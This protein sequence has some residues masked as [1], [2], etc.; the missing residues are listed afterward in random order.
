[1]K[2]MDGFLVK[3]ARGF[4]KKLL[5]YGVATAYMRRKYGMEERCDNLR[6]PGV[7]RRIGRFFV[8]MLP[9]GA[10]EW[11]QSRDNKRKSS[12][13]RNKAEFLGL[14]DR[15]WYV[16]HNPDVDFSAIDPL[17][18][19]FE[20]G[21]KEGRDP[22]ACFSVG[23]YLAK[24]DDVLKSGMNPLA[25]F[26]SRGRWEGR[27]AIAPGSPTGSGSSPV[28]R[29][30]ACHRTPAPLFSVVVASYNYEQLVLETLESLVAQTFRNFEVVVVDDG[31][32]DA[33]RENIRRFIDSHQECDIEITLLTH[34]GN[35]NRGLAETVRLGVEKSRG[36][37][38]AFCESDDLWK[39]NHLAVVAKAVKK[40]RGQIA[41]IVND[42][43][44][45]GDAERVA[46]FVGVRDSRRARLMSGFNSFSPADFRRMNYVLT[47]SAACARR[48]VLASCDFH[49]KGRQAALDWWLWRQVLFS[50]PLFY[51]DRRLTKWRMHKSL[52]T[53]AGAVDGM[54]E[55]MARKQKEFISAGDAVLR[56]QH[57]FSAW[58]KLLFTP[59]PDKPK[60]G[61]WLR[62]R[63]KRLI[64]YCIQRAYAYKKYFI[65]Y[66]ALGPIWAI[67]PFGLVCAVKGMNPDVG[68]GKGVV[69]SFLGRMFRSRYRMSRDR[70]AR[71]FAERK[72]GLSDCR[73]MIERNSGT[74]ILVVLHLFYQES[75]PLI[76]MYLEN[77]SRYKVDLV[78]TAVEGGCSKGTIA[79]IK[80]FSPSAR[81]MF[82]KNRGFDIGPFVLALNG[83]DLDSYDIV[84][85][86]HSKGI[87]RPS[88]FIYGQVFKYSDW[89]FN[90][91]DGVL[92][93]LVVHELIDSLKGG[94]CKLAAASNLIVA[95]PPHKQRFVKAF[96]AERGIEYVEDYVF[97]AGTC[98]AAS[99]D[100]FKPLKAM[101]LT[102]DDFA[103]AERGVFSAAH[104][105]ERTMCFPAKGACKGFFVNRNMYPRI[106]ESCRGKSALRLLDD[107][108]FVLD[109]DFFYRVLETRRVRSYEVVRMR[110]GDIQR[111]RNDGTICAL[112]ECEPF[113]YLKGDTDSY[114]AYCSD[115]LNATGFRMS[116]DRFEKLR[117]D[118]ET[119]DP[120][121]M[122]VVRGA[123]N[124][125]IDGQHRSCILL[126]RFGPDHEID[127]LRIW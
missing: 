44:I 40:A 101:G 54:T 20:T 96:C 116:T 16:S 110:L 91:F 77:L 74:R 71:F 62:G 38:V 81:I 37:Y 121:H 1:M 86:L 117:N 106:T 15:E 70:R 28:D 72:K 120:R 27:D 35:E 127:V 24:Y 61:K 126:D 21:W 118:M 26:I 89:F 124:I 39:P 94:R 115:N 107:P 9:Y 32:T 85:K 88:I 47:F 92:G 57:P 67:L 98:F 78:V 22:S 17:A 3:K 90:L 66:P 23:G 58:W 60:F 97:V 25:H 65:Y 12:R 5:P 99:A 19:F 83:I 56:R 18:H 7:F 93:G 31:S 95:D 123:E 105:L 36:E 113:R 55:E 104:A 84:F 43:E 112:S 63:V 34:P 13:L 69:E 111:R 114:E 4:V 79:A 64:P 100:V 73:D 122:P 33:S 50:R 125:I 82:C 2:Y 80:K 14:F 102:E 48:D 108:R 51:I 49:P 119:F 103:P 59:S 52:M 11:Y 10:V 42:V 109:D 29:D 46:K 6:S 76:Q 68:A 87:G 53:S 30:V 75:W 41:L 8:H 45:F